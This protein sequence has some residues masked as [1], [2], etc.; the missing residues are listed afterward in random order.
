MMLLRLLMTTN[1][2]R[3][4]FRLF[5]CACQMIL[6]KLKAKKHVKWN[7][8]IK[9]AILTNWGGHCSLLETAKPPE[10][11]MKNRKPREILATLPLFV[12]KNATYFTVAFW[13]LWAS[14]V[15]GAWGTL[16]AIA[17]KLMDLSIISTDAYFMTLHL[18]KKH[19]LSRKFAQTCQEHWRGYSAA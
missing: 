5:F 2:S 11:L 4:I 16:G 10:N 7:I 18:K 3:R 8:Y 13:G 15:T 9:R 6:N 17:R 19:S 1:R 12:K 14:S